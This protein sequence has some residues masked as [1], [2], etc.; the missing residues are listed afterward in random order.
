MD[1]VAD[2]WRDKYIAQDIC[3]STVYRG[4]TV[5]WRNQWPSEAGL[6]L[7]FFLFSIIISL[8]IAP[9]RSKGFFTHSGIFTRLRDFLS[10]CFWCDRKLR[11]TRRPDPVSTGVGNESVSSRHNR[12]SLFRASLL[13]AEIQWI[14]IVKHLS[15]WRLLVVTAAAALAFKQT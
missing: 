10:G 13:A 4:R 15:Q 12:P 9:V 2:V 1:L 11:Y 8:W 3:H 7:Q 5:A 6:L 14:L